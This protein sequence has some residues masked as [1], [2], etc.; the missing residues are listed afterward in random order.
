MDASTNQYF[1]ADEDID[2]NLNPVSATGN[3][4]I[5]SSATDTS[6]ADQEQR[7]DN[8]D[9]IARD[10][11]F[12][13][14]MSN[15][16]QAADYYRF[17]VP[18]D[19]EPSLNFPSGIRGL[20]YPGLDESED[21]NDEDLDAGYE[22]DSDGGYARLY[23][24]SNNEDGNEDEDQTEDE[25]ENDDQTVDQTHNHSDAEMAD[26]APPTPAQTPSPS[27]EQSP[28]ALTP[29]VNGPAAPSSKPTF[30]VPIPVPMIPFSVHLDRMAQEL[31]KMIGTPINISINMHH[32]SRHNP[33][34]MATQ[35]LRVHD[36][37][38]TKNAIRPLARA[39]RTITTPPVPDTNP[40]RPDAALWTHIAAYLAAPSGPPPVATCPICYRDLLIHGIPP[41]HT[42]LSPEYTH[43][44]VLPCAHMFCG[45]C[46]D[47]H[48]HNNLNTALATHTTITVPFAPVTA[49]LQQHLS[50]TTQTL[51]RTSAKPPIRHTTPAFPPSLIPPALRTAL[52]TAIT[53]ALTHTPGL[54]P[55]LLAKNHPARTRI[56]AL[57]ARFPV[58]PCCPLCKTSLGYA[59]CPHATRGAPI[60][61]DCP[62][63]ELLPC[64]QIPDT[65]AGVLPEM[66]DACMLRRVEVLVERAEAV[67]R[68]R[69]VAVEGGV[70]T[71]G[72]DAP[73]GAE[74]CTVLDAKREV[75]AVVREEWSLRERGR[76]DW[77]RW[78]YY[79]GHFKVGEF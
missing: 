52:T 21:Y 73:E 42:T 47:E 62:Q 61:A 53:A 64:A 65:G 40:A 4:V 41:R 18:W 51:A 74:G 25:N 37:L 16:L 5:D 45:A 75:E 12:N 2:L 38:S 56:H 58:A 1:S 72:V 20:R 10:T 71:E 17:D 13:N 7:A 11:L 31:N 26:N 15:E 22:L 68:S 66:C 76:R 77:G 67:A 60:G 46:I 48:L 9:D 36:T 19:I 79:H 32:A 14:L 70:V 44:V 35:G 3:S 50:P 23:S 55:P 54:L 6:I 78:V 28:L 29:L 24:D 30:T 27:G 43:G 57:T 69:G 59:R 33:A 8:S 39:P 49:T 34:D 63:S